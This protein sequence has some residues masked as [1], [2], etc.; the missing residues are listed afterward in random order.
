MN[1]GISRN[2][3][4]RKFLAQWKD[5]C[6]SLERIV[7]TSNKEV[8]EPLVPQLLSFEGERKQCMIQPKFRCWAIQTS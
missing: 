8:T 2:E 4:Q 5:S 1:N 7:W 3:L 6:N